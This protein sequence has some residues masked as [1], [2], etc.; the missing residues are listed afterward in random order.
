MY[1]WVSLL[2]KTL[3]LYTSVCIYVKDTCILN[4]YLH[5][6]LTNLLNENPVS[7]V[8]EIQANLIENPQFHSHF[9]WFLWIPKSYLF[10]WCSLSMDPEFMCPVSVMHQ[11]GLKKSAHFL[12]SDG[13]A[14]DLELQWTAHVP[15]PSQKLHPSSFLVSSEHTLWPSNSSL[16]IMQSISSLLQ[17]LLW[18]LEVEIH[19]DNQHNLEPSIH[20]EQP[21][22]EDS[23]DYKE[24]V[25]SFCLHIRKFW[26]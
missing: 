3:V 8:Q 2:N 17:S 4:L 24:Q 13:F 10:S 20:Q 22:L 26:Q 6:I 15:L 7:A 5:C 11:L 18:N 23:G 16:P 14:K 1:F 19:Q 25:F 12:S 21:S 9:L